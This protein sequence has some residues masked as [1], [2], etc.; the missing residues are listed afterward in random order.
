[1]VPLHVLAFVALYMGAARM[2]TAA[3]VDSST[4]AVRLM[5]ETSISELAV[6]TQDPDAEARRRF[7][8]RFLASH[9][10]MKLDLLD[11]QGRPILTS[12]APP[13]PI[14]RSGRTVSRILSGEIEEDYWMESRGD[15]TTML[16][17]KKVRSIGRCTSCHMEGEGLGIAS[18]T[19]NVTDGMHNVQRRVQRNLLL[20]ILGWAGVFFLTTAWVR[21]SA[22]KS[23]TTLARALSAVA[24]GE[25]REVEE[26]LVLEPTTAAVHRSL[27]DL[28]L[29]QREREA[30]VAERLVHTDQLAQ[31]GRMAAGL[32]H[33]IKNP[34]AGIQGAVELMKEDAVR[35]GGGESATRLH[36]EILTELKRVNKI[37]QSL[38][39]MARPT[40]PS[41]VEVDLRDVI[42][43]LGRLLTPSLGKAG[44][45][46]EVR[47]PPTPVRGV[48]DVSQLRQVLMNLI[49]NA[50]EEFQQGGTIVLSAAELPDGEC[51]IRVKDDGPGIPPN[52]LARLFEPFFTTKF[53]GTGLG[54]AI[55][56]SLVEQQG[57][58]IEVDSTVGEGSTFFVILQGR[59]EE[60]AEVEPDAAEE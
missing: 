40:P 23:A 54:L 13:D 3:F 48:T 28:L 47:V 10:L 37:L 7:L 19:M 59:G 30:E 29:R 38:L 12:T 39:E 20:L 41:L 44:V 6:V 55:A 45:R 9:E 57:G 50:A 5:M 31:L 1:M 17:L 21:R 24:E 34:L 11:P 22:E 56:R 33:E 42:E 58:S 14:T 32:A 51:V 26:N 25:A 4:E 16:G 8:E 2:M 27:K 43:D 46:L 18:V 52:V 36:V 15:T 60:S 53:S 49:N 35:A